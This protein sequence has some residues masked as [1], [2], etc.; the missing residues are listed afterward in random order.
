MVRRW[1]TVVKAEVTSSNTVGYQKVSFAGGLNIVGQQFV[2]VGGGAADIQTIGGNGLAAGGLDSIRTWNGIEYTDYY[3]YDGETSDING[4]GSDAWG[5]E[6]WE[7]VSENIPA[8]TAMW[9]VAQNAAS[10]SFSGEVPSDSSVSFIAG[11]NL[12]CPPQPVDIDIQDI[13]GTG[14]AAGGL[15]SIRVWNGSEYADY[16]FYDGET[17]DI[18][19][20]GSDAWGDENWEAVDVTI[21]A[22]HGF[23]LVSQGSGTLTFPNAIQSSAD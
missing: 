9:I 17:S 16:Y 10:L 15:D 20:D 13:S 23:W 7:A 18:N 22:G 4:D 8:G 1:R 3:F 5:D 6:N 12:I 21:P 11:L 19:G 14:L 2:A